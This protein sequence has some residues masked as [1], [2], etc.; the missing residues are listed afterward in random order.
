VRTARKAGVKQ[1]VLFH[2]DPDHDDQSLKR[3]ERLAER[4]LP[5][6]RVAYEGLEIKL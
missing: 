5:S 4:L 1:L 3:I 2:H 6:T